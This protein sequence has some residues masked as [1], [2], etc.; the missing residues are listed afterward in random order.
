M[1]LSDF[2]AEPVLFQKAMEEPDSGAVLA[3]KLGGE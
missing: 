2:S 1:D 3:N